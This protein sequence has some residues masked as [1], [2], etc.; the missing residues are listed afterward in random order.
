MSAEVRVV[1][2]VKG[3]YPQCDMDL[4]LA[5]EHL[6]K[7]APLWEQVEH[8]QQKYIGEQV[9][10]AICI[11]FITYLHLTYSRNAINSKPSL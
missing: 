6:K 8:N 9:S 11:Y 2:M 7:L 5:D 3:K 4:H 1:D 10:P